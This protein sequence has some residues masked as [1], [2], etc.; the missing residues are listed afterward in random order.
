MTELLNLE[1]KVKAHNS[2]MMPKVSV[3]NMQGKDR[4][5]G[6][7]PIIYTLADLDTYLHKVQVNDHFVKSRSLP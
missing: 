6:S 5:S 4:E 2:F 3:R 7:D 1:V